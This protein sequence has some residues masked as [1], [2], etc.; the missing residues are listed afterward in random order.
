MTLCAVEV[1][2]EPRG[3][4]RQPGAHMRFAAFLVGLFAV[5][6]LMAV[7]YWV[8]LTVQFAAGPINVLMDYSGQRW[9]V[10]AVL[11]AIVFT[12]VSTIVATLMSWRPRVARAVFLISAASWAII[13]VVDTVGV[14]VKWSDEGTAPAGSGP[15]S[16]V[17]N[18]LLVVSPLLPLLVASFLAGRARRHVDE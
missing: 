1:S 8:F 11:V 16:A 2:C 10:Q 7:G 6:L 5:L 17:L 12:L 15:L 14:V 13:A 3:S 9:L 4:K 18:V